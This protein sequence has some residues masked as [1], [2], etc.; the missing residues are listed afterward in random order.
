MPDEQTPAHR[1]VVADIR[2]NGPI[3]F[4]R[5]MEIALYG[6]HGYYSSLTTPGTDYATS[7]QMHPAFGALVAGYLFKAWQALDEPDSFHV[8]ELGAGDGI[9]AEDIHETVSTGV[10]EDFA[11]ALVYHP[12]DIRPRGSARPIDDFA[13]P[14]SVIGCVISNELIDAFPTHVFTI[15]NGD[16]LEL[17]VD[18]DHDSTLRFVEDH[19][20]DGGITDRVGDLAQYLP[21]TYRGEVNL[22][23]R[24][25]ANDVSAFLQSGYIL[26]IDYGHPRETLY[27]P[28]RSEGSLRCY[29]SHVLGQNPFRDV[30]RRDVTSHVDFTEIDNALE[31]VG[32][33][34]MAPLQT[35]RDFLFDLGIGQYSEHL[36]RSTALGSREQYARRWMPELRALNSLTDTRGLG[37]FQVAQ[38]RINAPNFDLLGLETSPVFP[39]PTL[40]RH[41]LEHLPYD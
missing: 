30:G 15:R 14:T 22:A 20:S 37:N 28:G 39:L 13:E 35:Q 4:A 21:N 10:H 2:A 25:W 38:H 19:P 5:F 40:K 41:H 33:E 36:R 27:H 1:S 6:E 18:A 12:L 34:Q 8:I 7:P 16:V 24:G 23:I 32:I 17:F 31:S 29:Q 26:T 9:L 11:D 3:T